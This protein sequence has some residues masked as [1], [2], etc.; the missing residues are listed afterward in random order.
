MIETENE[1]QIPTKQTQTHKLNFFG[2]S[3]QLFAGLYFFAWLV[4]TIVITMMVGAV[5]SLYAD[6]GAELPFFTGILV[7]QGLWVGLLSLIWV[8]AIMG[9][10]IFSSRT[11]FKNQRVIDIAVVVTSTA[12][13][14]LLA[15]TALAS[16]YLPIYQLSSLTQ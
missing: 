11:K 10:M 7:K 12:V 6:F 1:V 3:K 4:I 14:L 15:G 13:G 8:V 2:W 16:V 5:R 9:Y